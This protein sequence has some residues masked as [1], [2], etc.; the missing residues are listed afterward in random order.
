MRRSS[1][2]LFWRLGLGQASDEDVC[3]PPSCDT[4]SLLKMFAMIADEVGVK[5]YLTLVESSRT[6]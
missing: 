1:L 5:H 2:F 4:A 3:L 6:R